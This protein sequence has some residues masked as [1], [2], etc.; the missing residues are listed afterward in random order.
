MARRNFH[1]H[2]MDACA[3]S[4][5]QMVSPWRSKLLSLMVWPLGILVV[6]FHIA[7][8]PWR[9]C[10]IASAQLTLPT[11]NLDLLVQLKD[12]TALSLLMAMWS[13]KLVMILSISTWR[14][15]ISSPYR[16]ARARVSVSDS[17]GLMTYLEFSTLPAQSD[18]LQ[19]YKMV[20][21]GMST[22]NAT[23]LSMSSIPQ[24]QPLLV[25][26]IFFNILSL[27]LQSPCH[28][29][30]SSSLLTPPSPSP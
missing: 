11:V 18:Q 1:M 27:S 15:S 21:N 13:T 3:S 14:S 12:V 5:C 4:P 28:R 30:Q 24:R 22:M 26:P 2:A 19:Q 25:F 7:P 8:M 9:V 17:L 16:V 10:V 20:M 6:L 23:A 29:H